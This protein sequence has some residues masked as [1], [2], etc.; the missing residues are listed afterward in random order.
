MLIVLS[1]VPRFAK[2]VRPAAAALLSL[3]LAA[4]AVSA[5]VAVEEPAEEGV[6][7]QLQ[8]AP[9]THGQSSIIKLDRPQ[10][11]KL[12]DFCLSPSGEVV[13]LAVNRRIRAAEEAADAA[14][15]EPAA[16]ILEADEASKAKK[17]KNDAATPSGQI[18]I[19]DRDGKLLRKWD[20]PFHGQAINNA[21]DGTIY[22]A[23]DGRLAKYSST[24]QLIAEA[25]APHVTALKQDTELLKLRAQESLDA[26]KEMYT[27]QLKQFEEQLQQLTKKDSEKPT[28]AEKRQRSQLEQQLKIYKQAAEA[29]ERKTLETA[30]AAIM[31]QAMRL[32]A[33]AA[34]NDEVFFVCRATK[35]YG[36]C[37]WRTDKNFAEPKQIIQGL[38]GCCGQ[39]DVQC[40]G[41]ELLVAENSRHRV[42]RYD[43][44]GKQVSA[45]GKRD[46]DGLEGNFGGCCNPM[47]VCFNGSGDLYIAESNGS[48]K[49]FTPEGKYV[50][51]VGLAKVQ[52]GCKNSAIAASSDGDRVYYI[53]IQGSNIIVLAKNDPAAASKTQ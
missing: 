36:F 37:V 19:F 2:M 17:K 22:V 47:N 46:R 28:A 48:V 7:K 31:Q 32:N 13:A 15:G 12:E 43:R 38:S 11:M 23:G 34:T 27:Q 33:I 18:Q 35:G 21:P 50:G 40:S 10:D 45:F 39:M 6:P 26:E 1:E 51:V 41:A 49:H 24:G 29:V 8:K 20:V 44:E 42:V 4:S 14:E 5:E 53:D 30:M 9:A 52:P 3:I 25:G 16:S